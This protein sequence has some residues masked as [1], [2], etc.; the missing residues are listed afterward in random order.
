MARTE[1]FDDPNAPVSNS[2]VVAASA[3][4]V[5]LKN[6]EIARYGTYRTRDLVLASYGRTVPPGVAPQP[7]ESAR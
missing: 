4:V 3:A 2:L 7:R 6:N 1:Y 5:D